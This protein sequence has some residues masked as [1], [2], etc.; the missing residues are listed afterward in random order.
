MLRENSDRALGRL[1]ET[2]AATCFHPHPLMARLVQLHVKEGSL[3]LEAQSERREE[4]EDGKEGRATVRFLI[5][6]T[7]SYL[8]S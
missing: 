5:T 4:V 7:E 8:G 3:S 1:L 6:Y 2:I